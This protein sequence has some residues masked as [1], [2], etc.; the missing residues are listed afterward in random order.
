M[1]SNW[2]LV[3]TEELDPRGLRL[4]YKIDSYGRVG[5]WG[6]ETNLGSMT[7]GGWEYERDRA[8]FLDETDDPFGCW[9]WR[10]D[11][12]TKRLK[13]LKLVRRM[14]LYRRAKQ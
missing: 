9:A 12:I 4:W 3:T 1:K 5:F 11:V 2:R 7:N 14:E 10:H 8:S 13:W 6:A